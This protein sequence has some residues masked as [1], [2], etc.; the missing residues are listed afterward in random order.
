MQD[1]DERTQRARER[2]AERKLF[3]QEERVLL[4]QE[5]QARQQQ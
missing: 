4:R 3:E 5:V 2:A 1:E